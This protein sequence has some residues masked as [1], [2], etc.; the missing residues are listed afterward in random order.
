[1]PRMTSVMA[2]TAAVGAAAEMTLIWP[3]MK[4]WFWQL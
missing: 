3:T 1:M 4:S 2:G